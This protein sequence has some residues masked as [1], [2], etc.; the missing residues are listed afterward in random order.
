MEIAVTDPEQKS[1]SNISKYANQLPDGKSFKKSFPE[2]LRTEEIRNDIINNA[3][4]FGVTVTT[5]EIDD[6]YNTLVDL[7]QKNL[8]D[9]EINDVL[10]NL[11]EINNAYKV[12]RVVMPDAFDEILN[13]CI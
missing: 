9:E 6:L 8:S 12:F 10:S 1:V 3:S 13:Q 4:S 2:L 7:F 11:E 5:S